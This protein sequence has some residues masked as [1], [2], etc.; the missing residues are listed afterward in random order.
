MQWTLKTMVSFNNQSKFMGL[1]TVCPTVLFN[2]KMKN[3]WKFHYLA[4]DILKIY[5]I[6]VFFKMANK[7]LTD[8]NDG[9]KFSQ[10]MPHG[11]SVSYF[12]KL[13]MTW[14]CFPHFCP[15]LRGNYWWSLVFSLFLA[16]KG[17]GLKGGIISNLKHA[18]VTSLEISKEA[19]YIY[20]DL[21]AIS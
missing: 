17:C 21:T 2:L 5:F 3:T 14:Q 7:K 4:Y 19:W 12:I 10:M 6:D 1:L 15:F 11:I 8:D 20:T 18:H 16:W 9:N 13:Y